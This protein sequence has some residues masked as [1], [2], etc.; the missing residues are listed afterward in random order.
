M[1]HKIW[2][3]AFCMTLLFNG[4]SESE[5]GEGNEN[6]TAQ[7]QGWHQQGRDCLACHNEDLNPDKH[8]LFGGTLYK[9]QYI[10]DQNNLSSMCGG[11]LIV[12][13]LDENGVVQYS[14]KDFIANGSKGYKAK[15]NIFIMQRQLRL[16]GAGIYYI[17]IT[18]ANANQLAGPARH[19]FSSADYNTNNPT[20][21]NNEL[22]C[23]AC[24]NVG[25]IQY[26][27]YVEENG[28]LC[29]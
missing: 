29:R 7:A 6:S 4:C 19:T 27:L 9:D 21:P 10:T 13:F 14:S 11:D 15:G 1:L 3:S 20:D 18:D 8:L 24:H 5:N 23:N 26:P 25:G 28:N 2:L 17:Q 12:N 16:L 22:S